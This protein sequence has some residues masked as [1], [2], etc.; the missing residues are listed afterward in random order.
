MARASLASVLK[1]SGIQ[2]ELSPVTDEVIIFGGWKVHID[3]RGGEISLESLRQQMLDLKMELDSKALKIMAIIKNH[4][5]R[6]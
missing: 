2:C 6:T 5:P 1:E 3:S 4:E